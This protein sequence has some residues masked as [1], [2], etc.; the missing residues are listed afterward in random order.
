VVPILATRNL[1]H[2]IFPL[3]LDRRLHNHGMDRWQTPLNL[4]LG[5]PTQR[6]CIVAPRILKSGFD[7]EYSSLFVSIEMDAFS[8]S[9]QKVEGFGNF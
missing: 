9:A 5:Y 3:L 6:R 7:V 4:A 2:G 8:E 1:G